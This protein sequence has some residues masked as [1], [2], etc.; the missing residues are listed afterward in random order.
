MGIAPSLDAARAR[1]MIP[2]I[3]LVSAPHDT[4]ALSGDTI[5]ASDADL[6]VRMLS[7]GQ[8]HR[9]L[10]LTGSLCTAVAARMAG[11]VV[12]RLAAPAS[13]RPL[14]LA[15]P[16]GVIEVDATVTRNG[17]GWHAEHGSFFRT[18]RRLFEGWVHT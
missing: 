13:G 8:P 10:P 1:P 5:R 17:N 18:T 11:S 4:P 12:Q 2:F 14:R 3:A 15:M 7:N 6:V 16:S 9:A